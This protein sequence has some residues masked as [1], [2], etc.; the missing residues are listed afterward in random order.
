MART[1][2]ILNEDTFSASVAQIC[3]SQAD[4]YLISHMQTHEQFFT[5]IH[6][7]KPSAGTSRSPGFQIPY[8]E[9][10]D[11]I[12]EAG[13]VGPTRSEDDPY[14][15]RVFNSPRT[16]L[17][18]T[19]FAGMVHDVRKDG[20]LE[21]PTNINIRVAEDDPKNI[22]RVRINALRGPLILSG[23]GFGIDDMPVPPSGG[24]ISNYMREEDNLSFPQKARFHPS[25][26]NDR[27]RW[28]TGPINL[29]WDDERKVWMGGH[30]V[31]CGILQ[32]DI[33]APDSPCNP[34][35]FTIK[36]FRNTG[37]D[38]PASENGQDFTGPLTTALGEE[39]EIFNR[40]TS[41]EQENIQDTVFVIAIKLNYEWLPI[42][43]GCP[44][45][46]SDDSRCIPAGFFRDDV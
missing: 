19:D 7:R 34:T 43:V 42:W 17:G 30:H 32:S 40:D 1:D 8:Q 27:S 36:L 38:D 35:R 44:D 11:G 22:E 6:I 24:A 10:Q 4:Q 15:S 41:L 29:M 18:N 46:G 31:V 5:P 28:K 45:E 12:F 21:R 16:F 33:E 13:C 37:S 23:W 3:S 25:I 39:I 20:Q 2:T 26:G 9:R 14:F